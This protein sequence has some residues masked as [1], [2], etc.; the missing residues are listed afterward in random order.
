MKLL[1]KFLTF[2][3]PLISLI[4]LTSC[5]KEK[6]ILEFDEANTFSDGIPIKIGTDNT[7]LK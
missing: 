3:L 7:K 1:Y 4:F 6:K 2:T 5:S